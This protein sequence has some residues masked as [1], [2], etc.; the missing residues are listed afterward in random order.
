MARQKKDIRTCSIC[1]AEFDLV[2]EGGTRGYFG[3]LPVAFC[4]TCY[5]CMCDMV[6]QTID[7]TD[8]QK[9]I[10]GKKR[11]RKGI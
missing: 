6:M 11:M 3:I 9:L 5:A 1:Q 10:Y 8:M 2:G 7:D 4:P